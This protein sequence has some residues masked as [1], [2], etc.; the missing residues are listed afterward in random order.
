MDVPPPVRYAR[1]GDL[2][3]AYQVVGS[4]T[5]DLLW[6]IG[7]Y[8]HLDMLWENP[9]F[10]RTFE[11]LGESTRFVMFDKRGTGLSDRPS[12]LQTLEE[13]IDDIRVVLDA[14][15]SDRAFLMGF[16]EGGAMATLFA[17]TYPQRT[18]GLILYGAPVCYGRRPDWPYGTTDEEFQADW[19]RHQGRNFEDDFST[20]YWRRWFGPH[21]QDD[22]AFRDWFTR[23]RRAMG[24]P[25]TRHEQQQMNR[26]IDIR[27]ILQTVHTP[28]LVI[29]R[30]DDPVA[31]LE[32]VRWYSSRIPN[33]RL[34][35]LPGQGHLMFDVWDEWIAEVEAFVTGAPGRPRT[36]RFLTTLVAADIVNSTDLVARVG[37]AKWRDTLARHYE[38][39]ANR[40]SVYGG[41]EVDRA[42]DGFLAR[43]DGPA[44]AVRF[45]RDI[46]REDRTIGLRAR[47][48]VHTGEV[49]TSDGALRG[50]AV[51]IA[52]RLTS[53]AAPGEVVVS[54]TV[55]DLVGGA[56]F[57]FVDRGMHTLKGVP[58]PK[59]VFALA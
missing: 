2:N 40:L 13:R 42:G 57:T 53:I 44:R 38:L 55:K 20:E 5:I 28:T 49:E 31:P 15:G 58:E 25:T 7:S 17:A 43:F 6:C 9:S 4:G 29:V 10:A 33:A 36:D 47:A 37:D 50:I 21:L 19:H 27:D 16:S 30:E 39:V 26:L 56:G 23:T 8:S 18:R 12:H 35:V 22:L 46:D 14:V 54:S 1:S 45:A 34:V 24:S 51:H 41:V 59:Q 3:I 48:A 52:S 32:S 11:R